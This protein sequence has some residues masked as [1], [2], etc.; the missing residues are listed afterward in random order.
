MKEAAFIRQNIDKW[1]N[2]EM[3]VDDMASSTPDEI[4]EAYE[5]VLSDLSF[6]QTHF[7][8]S[9]ISG[10]LNNLALALH[11]NGERPQ[12]VDNSTICPWQGQVSI[13]ED[14]ENDNEN[15]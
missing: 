12:C 5:E 14:A 13:S 7:P 15:K 9:H 6:A 10:F 1:R 4:C 3:L 11:R 8:D 2:L